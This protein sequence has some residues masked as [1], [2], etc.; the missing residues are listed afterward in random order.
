MEK[1]RPIAVDLFAGAGGMTLGFEQAGFDVLASVEI[2]PIH[3]A[4][5]EFNFPFWTVLCQPMEETTA[6]QIRAN[7]AIGDREIDLVFGGP[8]CQGFSLIGKRCIEDPRNSLVFHYIRLVLELQPKFFI[9]ENVKGMTA[10]EHKQI[11]GEIIN[12]FTSNGYKIREQYQVLNAANFGVPQN[13]Q[14][15]F[16]IGCRQDLE[17]PNYPE[18]T[19][20]PAKPKKSGLAQELKVSPTVS[21]ALQ[22][23]PEIEKYDELYERDWVI[24]DF[25]KPS[26]YGRLMRGL[27]AANHDYSYPRQYD[28]RILTSSL[29]TK[30]SLETMSRFADTPVGKTEK[31]SRF[32]KLHPQGIS[33]TLRAGTAS[34]RGA[35]TS[36]RPI[37]PSIP[38][39]ITVREAAR[40]HSYPDWF[41]FHVTKWHGFRQIG[42][43]VPPLLAQA[44]ALE[45]IK[46]LDIKL[47]KPTKIQDLGDENL[48]KLDMKAAAKY[49]AVNPDVI[50]PRLRKLNI[51]SEKSVITQTS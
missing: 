41:R 23:L 10:G 15:L 26:D 36:P 6:E 7:S 49:F 50:E 38:R 8:P 3:C 1:K 25:G 45:I 46:C 2:D 21:E 9:M 44:V 4:T 47:N 22:D 12:K 19:T 39:C 34:N 17:L 16:L 48:L 32:H 28:S 14:R 24:A 43:S 13:R 18:A 27:S 33:N 20:Q 42:N 29:R 35:F 37:H 11:I 30:H 51:T 40:L 5:H 31:I